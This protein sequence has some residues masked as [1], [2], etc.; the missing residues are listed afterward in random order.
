M[1]TDVVKITWDDAWVAARALAARW[2]RCGIDRVYGVLAGGVPPALMVAQLLGV[3]V[4]SNV[5]PSATTLVVDD[6]VDSGKT[7]SRWALGRNPEGSVWLTD[8]LFRKPHSPAELAPEALVQDGWLH[9]PWEAHG[10]PTD[11]VTRLLEYIGEDPRRDG[12][13]DTPQRVVKALR[14]MTEGY[15]LDAGTILERTFDEHC[16]DMIVVRQVPFTS[17]CEHHLLP[18]TG[19]ATVGYIPA[20]S[21]GVVGLSKLARLVE[22]HARRLQVQERM[23]A[24]IAAD[25]EEHL[26]AFGVGVVVRAYHSCMAVR[27]VRKSAEMV[28]S[29]M[30]GAMRQ[31]AR[32]RAEFLDL[33]R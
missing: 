11:A 18:F 29:T 20:E 25:I 10:A 19:T 14:E 9:F 8:A 17:L 32:A 15:H 16:D 7:L 31:D 2:E 30:L 22:M 4:V 27:G 23:T 1:T 6:L 12:L 26:G 33:S 5:G 13:L 28:T 3:E 24:A 21:G